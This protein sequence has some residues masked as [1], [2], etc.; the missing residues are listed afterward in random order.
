M[1]SLEN[2][3]NGDIGDRHVDTTGTA[4]DFTDMEKSLKREKARAKS[5]FTRLKNKALFLTEQQE[6]P[7][8]QDIQDACTRV[9]SSME[10]AMVVITNLSEL[11]TKYN[12]NAYRFQK[13]L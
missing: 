9:D 10:S 12:L 3:S 8:Y 13:N 5:N 7:S 2:G 6:L 11:Y 1:A 4:G